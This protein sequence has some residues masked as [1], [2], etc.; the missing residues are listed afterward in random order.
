MS[1]NSINQL[2]N[3]ICKLK[4][5]S[6][7]NLSYNKLVQLPKELGYLDYLENLVSNF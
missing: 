4:N 6:T 7:L 1:H 5:L 3:E 2:P